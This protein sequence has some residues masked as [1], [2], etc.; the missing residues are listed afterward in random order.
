MDHHDYDYQVEHGGYDY[1][2]VRTNSS[3]KITAKNTL[4]VRATTSLL[5]SSSYLNKIAVPVSFSHQNRPWSCLKCENMDCRSG[6][7]WILDSGASA[8]FTSEISDFASYEVLPQDDAT[9]IQTAS[10]SGM[11]SKIGKGAVFIKHAV[12]E[13]GAIIERRTHIYPIYHVPEISTRLLSIGT[14]LLGYNNTIS[15]D[16]K[17]IHIVSP[18]GKTILSC[19]KAFSEDTVYWAYTHIIKPGSV[20]ITTVYVA[21][22]QIWHKRLGHLSEEALSKMPKNT[23]G[24]PE[25][26]TIK[27]DK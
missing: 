19:G 27:Y 16:S 9:I 5:S 24:F 18:M 2:L 17:R 11:I 20:N 25:K 8:H 26:L 23:I 14:L 4:S 6:A 12:E 1:R 3:Q 21:D 7:D 15:G 13:D 10:K 22:G